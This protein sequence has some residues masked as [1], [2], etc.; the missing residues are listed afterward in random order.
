M[1]SVPGYS[2]RRANMLVSP[3]RSN[4]STRR[5][6]TSTPLSIKTEIIKTSRQLIDDDLVNLS[7]YPQFSKFSFKLSIAP[8]VVKF[9]FCKTKGLGVNVNNM[10]IDCTAGTVSLMYETF[11]R[12]TQFGAEKFYV[13]WPGYACG[14]EIFMMAWIFPKLVFIGTFIMRL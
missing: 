2:L 13:V 1:E 8:E 12:I 3:S 7:K 10:A 6:R 9:N 5:S 11:L 14:Y 4:T